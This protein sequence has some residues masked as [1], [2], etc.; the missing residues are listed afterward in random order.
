VK[1]II[2]TMGE[3][4]VGPVL[5]SAYDLHNKE[6]LA[7]TLKFPELIFLDSGGYEASRDSDFSELGYYPHDPKPWRIDDHQGVLDAWASSLP[8]VVISYDHPKVRQPIPKQ[9]KRAEKLFEKLPKRAK[10]IL[11][12]PEGKGQKHVNIQAIV[13]NIKALSQFDVVGVTEKELGGSLLDR[14]K[15][16]SKIRDALK[17]TGRDIPI[18]VFGS[19][20]TITT[21]LYFISGADIFDGLTWLRFAFR[22][23]NTLYQHACGAEAYELS[24]RDEHVAARIW[25]DN[26]YYMSTLALE[27]KRFVNGNTSGNGSNFDAFKFGGAFFERAYQSLIA[28]RK[29]G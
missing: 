9:I 27:M 6:I 19:L 24:L 12:K 21:P 15:S 8:T 29:D 2:A 23:G 3:K 1:K 7:K 18:H 20:D 25:T 13:A 26:Y 10:E 16:I 17:G 28:A 5:V 22:D 14:M 4:L 11:L